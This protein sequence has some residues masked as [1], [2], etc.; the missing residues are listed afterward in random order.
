MPARQRRPRGHIET[1]PNGTF[2]ASVYAGIDPLTGK[3]RYLRASAK[4][5]RDAKRELTK[6]QTQVDDQRH[7]RTAATV[8]YVIDRWL[9]VTQLE[10]TTRQRYEGLIRRYIRPTFGSMPA[11]KLTAELLERFYARLQQCNKLCGGRGKDHTCRPLAASTVRQV[12]FIIRATLDRAVRWRYLGTN[13]AALATPPTFDRSEPD[14]PSAAEVSAL[15]NE[16]WRDPAW[17]MFIWLTLVTGCRRGEMCALR[18]TDVDL[19]RGVLTVER[20]FAQTAGVIREKATKTRQKR[21]VALD[22]HTVELLVAHHAQCAAECELLGVDLPRDAFVF[23]ASPDGST[24]VSPST[25]TQRYRR[26]AIRLGLRSSRI[27]ALRHYSAT[28]LLTAGV[29]LRTVAGRL[30]HASGGATTLRFYAAWVDEADRRAADAIAGLMPRPNP[31]LRQPRSPYERLAAEL[32]GA[33][34]SGQLA[35]GVPL[36]TAIELAAQHN[37]SAGTVSRA[38]RLLRD[39]GLVAA[40]RGKRATVAAELSGFELRDR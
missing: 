21:R 39:A 27:H 32:R 19:A 31:A 37:V 14:P 3:E 6:L 25:V 12:H 36:P 13:E 24:P 38:I 17:G 16:A 23:S 2:R 26:L 11:A 28:E 20:S 15:L 7:P 33:I 8:G 35:P 5:Y 9:E 4:T 34:E 1:R 30:G 22:A 40:S 18:W 29:D 10:D